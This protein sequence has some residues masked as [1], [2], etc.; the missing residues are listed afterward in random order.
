MSYEAFEMTGVRMAAEAAITI[1][2]QGNS[3]AFALR[4]SVK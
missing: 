3:P 4:V 2:K 1:L